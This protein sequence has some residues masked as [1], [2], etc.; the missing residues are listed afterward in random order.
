MRRSEFESKVKAWANKHNVETV[1]KKG[2]FNTIIKAKTNYINGP[3][4]INT[5]ATISNNER[6]KFALFW[7]PNE[8]ITIEAK[9]EL[10]EI[11]V[12]FAK[13]WPNNREGEGRFIIPLPNLK[14]TDGEQ[15]YLTHNGSFFAS[16]RDNELKQIWA[17][18]DLKDIP[19]EYRKYAI[20]ISK[21]EEWLFE[22]RPRCA[23]E[24]NGD[25]YELKKVD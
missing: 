22:V 8:N 12:E 2:E 21:Y 20:D 13:T 15:Q 9:D 17:E 1:I 16:R 3:T 7:E 10:F 19:E 25:V 5:L 4:F 23:V 24:L 14:T 11:I 6:L 18:K